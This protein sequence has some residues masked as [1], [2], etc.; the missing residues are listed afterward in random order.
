MLPE[1]SK[2]G[3]IHFLFSAQ[4]LISVLRNIVVKVLH[5]VQVRRKQQVH[6]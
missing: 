2:V 1:G 5:R 6:G 3:G 4:T